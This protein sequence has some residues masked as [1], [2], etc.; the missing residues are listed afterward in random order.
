M[1][2]GQND[3]SYIFVHMYIFNDPTWSSKR[4][5]TYASN[6][7]FDSCSFKRNATA[8]R[9]S[10]I[11][12]SHG[13]KRNFDAWYVEKE[14]SVSKCRLQTAEAPEYQPARVGRR[15]WRVKATQWFHM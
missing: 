10:N 14:G 13:L 1:I 8:F 6:A 2:K 15:T 11:G 3:R 4:W 9:S 12:S 7:H 5:S